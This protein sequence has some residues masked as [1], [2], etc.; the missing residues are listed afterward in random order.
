[1]VILEYILILV[2]VILLLVANKLIKSAEKRYILRFVCCVL[3]IVLLP[4]KLRLCDMSWVISMVI[5]VLFI[6]GVKILG[7]RIS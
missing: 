3:I 4:D 1:M 6:Y 7:D 2:A 5:T